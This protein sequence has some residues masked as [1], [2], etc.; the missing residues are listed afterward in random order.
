MCFT[1]CAFYTFFF[2]NPVFQK[3][4]GCLHVKKRL[5]SFVDDKESN[6]HSH[7]LEQQRGLINHISV[8]EQKVLVCR[9]VTSSTST[10]TRSEVPG[11][12]K[13]RSCTD[14]PS[15]VPRSRGSFTQLCTKSQILPISAAFLVVRP[16]LSRGSRSETSRVLSLPCLMFALP[17]SQRCIN[18]PICPVWDVMP[19]NPPQLYVTSCAS[20]CAF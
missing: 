1:F 11:R 4:P 3:C 2:F 15:S 5:R 6:M 20:T 17:R 10:A 7:L 12:W 9:L 14:C 16:S 18:L 8:S 13:G 19:T